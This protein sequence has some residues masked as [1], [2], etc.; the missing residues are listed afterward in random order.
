GCALVAFFE[1]R[2]RQPDVLV[3]YETK[4]RIGVRK[5][6]IYPRHFS[7]PFKRTTSPIQ[8]T[9][10]ATAAGNLG[11]RVKLVGSVALSLEHLQSL[12]RVGGWNSEAVTRAANAAQ[13]LLA[14]C[15]RDSSPAWAELW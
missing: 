3:I 11:V 2:L 12:I 9:V 15:R 8:L 4:C 14:A 10:E 13:V 6:M 7:L 1:Y 5:A